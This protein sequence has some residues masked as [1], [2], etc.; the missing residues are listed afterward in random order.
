MYES[1]NLVPLVQEA[2]VGSVSYAA[3][4][5]ANMTWMANLVAVANAVVY[6]E[7]GLVTFVA[8]LLAV[9]TVT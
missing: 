8:G 5:G 4:V 7:V 9:Y 1:P 2:S 6:S 3:D